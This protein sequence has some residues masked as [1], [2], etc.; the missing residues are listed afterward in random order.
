MV[1]WLGRLGGALELAVSRAEGLPVY[2]KFFSKL[3]FFTS[4]ISGQDAA[5]DDS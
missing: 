4:N 5:A 2:T 3:R 1:F